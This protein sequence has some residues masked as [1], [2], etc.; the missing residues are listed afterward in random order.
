METS[1]EGD[2]GCGTFGGRTGKQ[3][4]SGSVKKKIK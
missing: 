2:M 1:R 3:I 4:K